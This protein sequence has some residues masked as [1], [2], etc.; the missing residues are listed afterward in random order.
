MFRIF[1][2]MFPQLTPPIY[3]SHARIF[4]S[5][6]SSNGHENEKKKKRK[7]ERKMQKRRHQDGQYKSADSTL[8]KLEVFL[9]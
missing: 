2:V 7:G 3:I 6:Q 5:I 8:Y 4:S 9:A 1:K